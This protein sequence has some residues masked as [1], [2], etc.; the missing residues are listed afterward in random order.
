MHFKSC[1]DVYKKSIRSSVQVIIY[2]MNITGGKK[3]LH[4]QFNWMKSKMLD[5]VLAGG[6]SGWKM[7]RGGGTGRISASPECIQKFVFFIAMSL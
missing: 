5:L 6:L 3:N 1:E 2:N 4:F 7:G